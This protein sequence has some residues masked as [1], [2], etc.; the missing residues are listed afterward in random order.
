MRNWGDLTTKDFAGLDPE[1]AIALMPLGAVEQHGPHL[2]LSTD[3]VIAGEIARRGAERAGADVLLLPT[4]E[5]GASNE[6]LAFPGTLT[7][8]AQTLIVYWTE[9]GESVARA[10]LRKLV[11]LNAHGGQIAIMQI[12]ARELRIRCQ[13]LA[14]AA[15]TWDCGY[16]AGVLPSG[17]ATHGIHGGQSETSLLLHLRPELVRMQHAADFVPATIAF[18]SAHE[19]L[20]MVGTPGIGWMAQDLHPEGVAG[21]AAA[22]SAETGRQIADALTKGLARLIDE[23]S[24]TPLSILKTNKDRGN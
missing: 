8:S 22:A 11:M 7:L 21:N 15:N 19:R 5:I 13:M 16:P 3:A 2:P 1:R 23:L 6:H 14:V 17:E 10:G 20:R 24:A 9:I 18:N 4:L 12:V